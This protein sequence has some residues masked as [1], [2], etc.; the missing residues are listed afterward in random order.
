[1]ATG[2]AKT[3]YRPGDQVPV[4]GI[5]RVLHK[6]HRESHEVSLTAKDIFPPCGKCGVQVRFELLASASMRGHQKC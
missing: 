5:Y 2:S 1:M 3:V 4:D 6:D